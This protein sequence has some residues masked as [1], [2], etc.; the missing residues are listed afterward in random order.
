M[1][2]DGVDSARASTGVPYGIDSWVETTIT[3][4]GLLTFQWIADGGGTSFLVDGVEQMTCS[5]EGLWFTENVSIPSGPHTVRWS[6]SGSYAVLTAGLDQVRWRPGA[7]FEEWKTP[8]FTAGERADQLVSGLDADPDND[9]LPNGVEATLGTSPR[10]P[11]GGVFSSVLMEIP[12][13]PQWAITFS[14]SNA[15]PVDLVPGIEI[16]TDIETD[17][18]YV[19]GATSGVWSAIAPATVLTAPGAVGFTG[20]TVKVPGTG[21]RTFA[22]LSVVHASGG[23]GWGSSAAGGGPGADGCAGGGP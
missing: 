12:P 2:G 9:G 5:Y 19:A 11:N 18:H 10:S 6:Q 23:G 20:V 22:R 8:Y 1:S 13:P 21:H 17:W 16:S 3:G 4:P 14:V 15:A 7:R